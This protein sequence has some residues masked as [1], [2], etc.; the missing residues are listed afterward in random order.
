MPLPPHRQDW[1]WTALRV[2]KASSI[3]VRAV[4]IHALQIPS[5][6]GTEWEGQSG[7]P[8]AQSVGEEMLCWSKRSGVE[9]G[10]EPSPSS[11][12]TLPKGW[13]LLCVVLDPEN[14]E[15]EI[16]ACPR[17]PPSLPRDAQVTPKPLCRGIGHEARQVGLVRGWPLII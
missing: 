4:Q 13:Y 7:W 15:I 1:V 3:E 16:W 9:K 17:V 10:Q 8:R 6:R 14:P 12:S 5:T 11:P 2:V